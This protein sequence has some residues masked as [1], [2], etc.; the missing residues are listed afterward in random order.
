MDVK[1]FTSIIESYLQEQR[2]ITD[3]YTKTTDSIDLFAIFTFNT[4]NTPRWSLS[5]LFMQNRRP[6]YNGLFP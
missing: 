3:I 2:L 6:K 5:I 4:I 1:I